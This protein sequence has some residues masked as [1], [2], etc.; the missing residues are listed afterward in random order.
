M[1]SQLY[2]IFEGDQVLTAKN[3]NDLRAYLDEQDRVSR[4][5]LS[6]IGIVCGL[7]VKTPDLSTIEITE[8]VGVTSRGYLASFPG[9]S[10]T[11]IRNYTDPGTIEPA[12]GENEAGIYPPFKGNEGEQIRLWELIEVEEEEGEAPAPDM[13]EIN[14]GSDGTVIDEDTEE[15]IKFSNYCVLLYLEMNDEDLEDCFG[16]DCDE[17]GIQRNFVWRKL[18]IKKTDL[19]E[20]IEALPGRAGYVDAISACQSLDDPYVER[21]GYYEDENLSLLNYTS[22]KELSNDYHR[23]IEQAS[24]RVGKALHKSYESFRPVLAETYESH[25]FPDFNN[26]TETENGLFKRIRDEVRFKPTAIQYAY[27]FLKDLVDAY[28]EFREAACEIAAVC[29]PNPEL[30]PRH[31]MLDYL[32]TGQQENKRS[33][34]RH[35]FQPSPI[36]DGHRDLKREARHLHKRLVNMI[37]QFEV[38]MEED[39]EIRIT[40]SKTS[41]DPLSTRSI[42]YY[43]NV[44]KVATLLR[45]WNYQKTR[46]NKYELI[47]SYHADEYAGRSQVEAAMHHYDSRPFLRIEGH[48]GRNYERVLGEL[49]NLQ[50]RIN[51]PVKVVG[52]KLSQ[53]F[54]NTKVSYE[55]RFEDLQELYETFKTELNCLLD[56][57]MKFFRGLE[58][59]KESAEEEESTGGGSIGMANLGEEFW[60]D[61]GIA[62]FHTEEINTYDSPI[63]GTRRYPKES[64]PNTFGY[65]YDSLAARKE[66]EQQILDLALNI[67]PTVFNIDPKIWI[68]LFLKPA[69]LANNIQKLLKLLPKRLED[70]EIDE[71]EAAYDRVIQTAKEYKKQ[72]KESE[73]NREQLEGKEQIII[74]RLDKLI[75]SCSIKKLKELY[76][77]YRDRIEKAQQMNLFS[78]FA[79]RHSGMEHMAGVPKGGTF[80][81]VYIDRNEEPLDRDVQIEASALPVAT[82]VNIG[83]MERI[84][85]I[86]GRTGIRKKEQF[87]FAD[88]KE[89]DSQ[90][91]ILLKELRHVSEEQGIGIDPDKWTKL[92]KGITDKIRVLPEAEVDERPPDNV[93]VADFALP[94]LCKSDCPELAT[95][96]ISQLSFSLPKFQFCKKDET[97]YPFTVHPEGGVVESKG[98]GV[99]KEGEKWFFIPSQVVTEGEDI[100]FTYRVNNQTVVY[101]AKIFN[102][103]ADFEFE[104]ETLDDG[105]VEVSFTNKSTGGQSYEWKFGDGATSTE[106]NPVHTYRDFDNEVAVVTLKASKFDCSDEAIKEVDI[107]QE[108]EV[109]F[110]LLKARIVDGIYWLCENDDPYRFVTKPAGRPITGDNSGVIVGGNNERFLAPGQ[111]EPGTY[112]LGYAGESMEVRILEVPTADFEI[113]YIEQGAAIAQVKLSRTGSGEVVKWVIDGK[114]YDVQEPEHTFRDTGEAH[115][116]TM[117]VKF[118]NGCMDVIKRSV[119]IDFAGQEE[120]FV[121]IDGMLEE[122][123]GHRNPE[124][125]NEIFEEG[126]PLYER[127]KN[128]LLSIKEGIQDEEIKQQYIAGERNDEIAAIYGKRLS[129]AFSRTAAMAQDGNEQFVAYLYG[130]YEMEL[131]QLLDIIDHQQKDISAESKMGQL[132]MKCVEQLKQLKELGVTVDPNDELAQKVA[133]V[134][135]NAE[136]EGKDKLVALLEQLENEL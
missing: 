76:R 3:L 80:V 42:P 15:A 39:D 1:D 9:A 103:Q 95:M 122:V 106:E 68:Y 123:D 91:K 54:T 74:Y 35:Y 113:E 59:K 2:N 69:Q 7:E 30:F 128:N 37:E 26:D 66:G 101:N 14:L 31:L 89:I 120:G 99:V 98:G 133:E 11:Y 23:I 55:C 115:T 61:P 73:E 75:Y 119:F 117:Q 118:E 109:E 124:M 67:D 71:I 44:D 84:R 94:Y 79:K 107:P 24:V 25:P 72:L 65:I 27:D 111:Y 5:H 47:P 110:R 125:D 17:N 40:P 56:E 131:R 102:P 86:S 88:K 130:Y 104:V 51:V 45:L 82:E 92:N 90:V 135:Q 18:L 4:T 105:S 114:T 85:R 57:Q 12:P 87:T 134:K 28:D 70:I 21:L 41:A 32:G 129:E 81:L 49:Q 46:L 19:D 36:L 136:N 6:G 8:G 50:N 93:V 58:V 34:Y 52:V 29:R 10:C 126:N 33:A 116:I 100:Q 97:K 77:I 108:V 60:A 43:Y 132:L 16:D 48:V 22:F 53:T 96:V 83:N 78:N 20:I 121:D 127:L 62:G 112:N 13:F 63:T 38:D 64:N